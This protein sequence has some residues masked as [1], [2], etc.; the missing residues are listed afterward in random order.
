MDGQTNVE[1]I[2]ML[3]TI[4]WILKYNFWKK[5]LQ[6]LSQGEKGHK[7][8][9]RKFHMKIFKKW[10]EM[11]KCKGYAAYTGNPIAAQHLYF[12]P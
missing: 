9:K 5:E 6:G 1:I 12:N 10:K 4:E 2:Q 8:C 11:R 3:F 7:K